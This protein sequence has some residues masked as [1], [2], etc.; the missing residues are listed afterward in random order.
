MHRPRDSAAPSTAARGPRPSD[1]PRRASSLSEKSYHL[2]DQDGAIGPAEAQVENRGVAYRGGENIGPAEAQAEGAGR[3]YL[4]RATLTRFGGAGFA[5]GFASARASSGEPVASLAATT[6][7]TGAARCARIGAGGEGGGMI[8]GIEVSMT[9]FS[10]Q[11]WSD[12][13]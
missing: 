4:C 11:R 5:A 9:T 12:R 8:V 1:P 10:G 2:N 7:A 3:A 6:E 13:M